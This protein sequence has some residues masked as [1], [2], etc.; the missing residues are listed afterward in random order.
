MGSVMNRNDLIEAVAE[1]H[2]VS[3]AF[4]RGMVESVFRSIGA[5]AQQGKEVAISGFGKFRVVERKA[6][7]GRNPATGESVKIAASKSLRFQPAKA[8]KTALNSRRRSR[9]KA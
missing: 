8:I 4:A 6:R 5:A 9:K 3:K 1:E 7:K 2:E